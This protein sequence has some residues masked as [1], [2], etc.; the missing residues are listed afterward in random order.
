MPS[1]NLSATPLTRLH[2]WPLILKHYDLEASKAGK[3][4]AWIHHIFAK[5]G[6]FIPH[7][8]IRSRVLVDAAYLSGSCTKLLYLSIYFS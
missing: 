6:H 7:L 5:H 8:T 3:D 4:E 2:S 1:Y